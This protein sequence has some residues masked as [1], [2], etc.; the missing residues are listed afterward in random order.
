MG[1]VPV[2]RGL[3]GTCCDNG[4][5]DGELTEADRKNAFARTANQRSWWRYWPRWTGSE[6]RNNRNNESFSRFWPLRF[7][8]ITMLKQRCENINKI[9]LTRTTIQHNGE[10]GMRDN[11]L[12]RQQLQQRM[13]RLALAGLEKGELFV[14]RKTVGFALIKADC[15]ALKKAGCFV[16]KKT[17]FLPSKRRFCCFEKSGF[18]VLRTVGCVLRGANATTRI[19]G[20]PM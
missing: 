9:R 11:D 17:V 20:S 8:T 19:G 2:P 13:E 1:R 10:A 14:L 4:T 12:H 3:G 5:I 15:F 7:D 6:R 16:L 18:F